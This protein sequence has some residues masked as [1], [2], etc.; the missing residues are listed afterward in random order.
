[1]IAEGMCANEVCARLCQGQVFVPRKVLPNGFSGKGVFPVCT[2]DHPTDME[3][4]SL[5]APKRLRLTGLLLLPS[6]F[7]ENV[8]EYR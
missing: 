2:G 1:M 6:N 4:E 5:V 8:W 7:K 3:Q